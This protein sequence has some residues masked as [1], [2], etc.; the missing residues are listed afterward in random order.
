[1]VYNKEI[2]V[3]ENKINTSVKAS[4]I[5]ALDQKIVFSFSFFKGF[6]IKLKD[7]NNHYANENDAKK[8]VS[9][10][11]KTLTSISNMSSKEFYSTSMKEQLHFNPFTNNK[12]IDRI[13]NILIEG[14]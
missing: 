10:F 6:S 11:F 4:L 8:S 7:F 9:D 2:V 12:H 13:E 14:Y 5:E 1:M 3:K